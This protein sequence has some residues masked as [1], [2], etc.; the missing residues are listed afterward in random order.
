MQRLFCIIYYLLWLLCNDKLRSFFSNRSTLLSPPLFSFYH[1]LYNQ[2]EW[3][4]YFWTKD[5]YRNATHAPSKSP[6]FFFL[7][8]FWIHLDMG[9]IDD[10]SYV[11]FDLFYL[12]HVQINGFGP[13]VIGGWL[14]HAI[15][16]VRLEM[17]ILQGYSHMYGKWSADCNSYR[18]ESLTKQRTMN[19]TFTV[20]L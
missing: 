13:T 19:S 2:C 3:F 17:Y 11:V 14:K 15:C 18:N 4:L 6:F 20:S 16:I 7:E 10:H 1:H 8:T 9:Q 12:S 5:T